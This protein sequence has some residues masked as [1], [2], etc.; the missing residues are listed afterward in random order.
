MQKGNGSKLWKGN[1]Q[2]LVL[3]KSGIS[4]KSIRVEKFRKRRGRKSLEKV[5]SEKGLVGK[6]LEG[7]VKKGLVQKGLV[8][9]GPAA[10]SRCSLY[11]RVHSI[12]AARTYLLRNSRK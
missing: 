6:G 1:A 9:K 3:K 4:V 7:L 5:L 8:G 11:H 12:F 10:S 2:R